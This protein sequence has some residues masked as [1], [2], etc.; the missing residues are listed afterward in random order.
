[1]YNKFKGV[2]KAKWKYR[3]TTGEAPL[4]T[5]EFSNSIDAVSFDAYTVGDSILGIAHR[6]LG[7]PGV[8][9]R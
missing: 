2:N 3:D 6:L 5:K 4:R 8:D 7:L 9:C 1:V